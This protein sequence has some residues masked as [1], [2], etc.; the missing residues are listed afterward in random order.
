MENIELYPLCSLQHALYTKDTKGMQP[1]KTFKLNG[2]IWQF[3]NYSSFNTFTNFPIA[4][5]KKNS[6]QKNKN[7]W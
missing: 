6:K 2:K 3:K 1:L 7:L 4:I 5:I